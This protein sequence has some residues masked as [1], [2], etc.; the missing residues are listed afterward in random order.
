MRGKEPVTQP[1]KK[2]S[3]ITPAYAGK[4]AFAKLFKCQISDHPRVCGEK[5]IEKYAVEMQ[6]DHP[7]VC[8]E[9]YALVF[10]SRLI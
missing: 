2:P 6:Q 8:G 7:R 9:K 5:I 1:T 3:G 4:S 10:Y